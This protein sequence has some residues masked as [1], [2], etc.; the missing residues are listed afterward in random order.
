LYSLTRF[1]VAEKT[2]LNMRDVASR[3]LDIHFIAVSHSDAPSTGRWL[4]S[5]P[6]PS[7]NSD[8]TILVDDERELYAT[9]GLG[10]SSFWHVLSP[11]S[12]YSAYKLGKR[13]SIWNRPTESGTRWQTSGSFAV[14]GEG[15]VKWSRPSASADEVPDFED[16][17]P[18]L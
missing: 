9:W 17:L 15:I 18:S 16:A 11:W 7:K 8:V 1:T 5:L 2:F 3:H 6:D 12:L 13:D 4:A 10:V 14:N